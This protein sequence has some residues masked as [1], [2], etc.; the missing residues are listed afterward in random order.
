M[1]IQRG[2]CAPCV[3]T[4]VLREQHTLKVPCVVGS[5]F[6]SPMRAR[7]SNYRETRVCDD[8]RV[9]LSAARISFPTRTHHPN[10]E[11]INRAPRRQSHFAPGNSPILDRVN[12]KSLGIQ[13]PSILKVPLELIGTKIRNSQSTSSS[14]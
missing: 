6:S 1:I 5:A 2:H 11:F 7:I 4:R 13:N 14:I 9:L 10:Y 12:E 3:N 8:D